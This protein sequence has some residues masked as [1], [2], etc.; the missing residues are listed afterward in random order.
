MGVPGRKVAARGGYVRVPGGRNPLAWGPIWGPPVV[1]KS[2][3]LEKEI[4]S[5]G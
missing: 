3:D 1:R 2:A 5:R 4:S